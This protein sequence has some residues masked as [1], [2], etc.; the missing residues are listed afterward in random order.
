MKFRL[1]AVL[2]LLPA[3]AIAAS[4]IAGFSRSTP[5]AKDI[6][7]AAI[8]ESST[9]L[10]I[11]AYQYTNPDIIR[12]VITAHQRGVKVVVV[13]DRTQ[14]NG[15][16]QAAMV[17]AGIPCRIDQR[18]KIM[19]HKFIISDAIN[20]QTGSFNYTLNGD[21]ANA[22]NAIYIRGVPELAAAYAAEF[23]KLLPGTIPCPGGGQ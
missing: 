18:F 1:A 7:L 14:R 4:V 19:H 20:V 23:Q 2:A 11:A 5:S 16:S 10:H 3:A 13:L 8:N 12:A 21:R 17:A 9:S 6:A 22:E 15:D